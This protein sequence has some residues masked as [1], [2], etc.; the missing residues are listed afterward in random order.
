MPK[1]KK[2]TPA[3]PPRIAQAI[4][5]LR[6]T[7]AQQYYASALRISIRAYQLY[8]SGE[9]VPEPRQLT[10]LACAAEAAGRA[11]L[12]ELFVGEIEKQLAPLPGFEV[13]VVFRRREPLVTTPHWTPGAV[14]VI[15]QT[16]IQGYALPSDL[17]SVHGVHGKRKK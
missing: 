10:A 17:E 16:G 11:D 5:A 13:A 6:G 7:E 8:E 2:K 9:R 15:S 14:P 4:R 12:V 3:P 1:P